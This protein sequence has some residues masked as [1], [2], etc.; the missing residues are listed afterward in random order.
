[1][2]DLSERLKRWE[3]PSLE[4]GFEARV[5]RRLRMR[6]RWLAAAEFLIFVLGGLAGAG[7]MRLGERAATADPAELGGAVDLAELVVRSP[8]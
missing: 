4:P 2:D 7:L 8:R 5:L 6:R 1:M 3:S